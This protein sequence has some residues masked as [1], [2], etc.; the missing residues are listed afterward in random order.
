MTQP[1]EP[2]KHWTT[3]PQKLRKTIYRLTLDWINLHRDLPTPPRRNTTRTS[4]TREYGHPAEW[5]SDKAREIVDVLTSWHE[6]LADHRHETPPPAG[7][8]Q[9]RLT[10]AWIY[11]EPRCPQLIAYANHP[12]DGHDNH[13][14]LKELPDL[15]H[16]I[17][18]T[19]GYNNPR[20]TLPV[21]CPNTDCGLRTLERVVGIGTDYIA[22]GHCDYVVRDDPEGHNYQWLIRVCIDTLVST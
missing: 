6:A 12:I 10:A 19:L 20:Y 22:C 5:A 11:L 9:R 7:N 8:E 17:R 2:I 21:P 15:H 18:N 13:E 4:N 14:A 3:T 16:G 1:T